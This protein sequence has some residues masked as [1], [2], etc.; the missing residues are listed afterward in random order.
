[1]WILGLKELIRFYRLHLRLSRDQESYIPVTMSCSHIFL[2]YS[3]STSS[4]VAPAR[5]SS[6][7]IVSEAPGS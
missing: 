5:P 3:V 1:M 6:S 2:M 4:A 7:S